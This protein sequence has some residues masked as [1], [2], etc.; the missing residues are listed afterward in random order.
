MAIN[1]VA[2]AAKSGRHRF[3][4]VT[5]L[6]TDNYLPGVMALHESLIRTKVRYPLVVLC[7]RA[8]SPAAKDDLSWLGID[9]ITVSQDI[10]IDRDIADRNLSGNQ[11]HWSFTFNKLLIFDLCQF[12]KIVYLDSDMII[13]A[14]LD[15]LFDRPHMSASVAGASLPGNEDW[16]DLNSGLMVIVPSADI[17]PR[18]LSKVKAA[19]DRRG[20]AA[21]GD[22]DVLHEA[23]PDWRHKPELRLDESYNLFT[24]HLDH[25]V[26]KLG[27]RWRGGKPMHVLHY[28]GP[29]KPWMLRPAER[30][31]T[32]AGLLARRQWHA[33]RA[34]TIFRTMLRRARRR[35]AQGRM[36]AAR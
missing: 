13:L 8:V 23:D 22:Q 19:A 5:V 7:G 16:A 4:Y 33:W 26:R 17:L 24:P 6:S 32:Y 35:L 31:R 28:I 30:L 36:A 20:G 12:E 15:H 25:Y 9:V 29:T 10:E 21:L 2:N 1:S 34:L 3:A 14:N 27:Y 11:A 18:L